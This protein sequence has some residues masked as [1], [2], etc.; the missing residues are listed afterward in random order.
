MKNTFWL[1]GIALLLAGQLIHAA[2]ILALF[3]FPGKSHAI[4]LNSILSELL[5]RGHEVRYYNDKND[6]ANCKCCT[7]R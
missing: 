2:T 3:P 5:N 7:F 4:M 1:F 6:I